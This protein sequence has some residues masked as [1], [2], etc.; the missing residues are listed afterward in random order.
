MGPQR[1]PA[2][3]AGGKE[4][5]AS[6]DRAR[7]GRQ[8]WFVP[9]RQHYLFVCTNLRPEGNPKGSC[10]AKGSEALYQALKAELFARGL[11]K[12]AARAC[13]SSCLDQCS[14][15]ASILVEPEHFFY[16]RVTTADVPEIVEAL[17]KGERVERL[18]MTGEDLERG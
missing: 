15:G 9:Q 17:A 6:L 8:S 4:Q 3:A 10:A 1:S 13:T 7:S 12:T 5:P 16:G 2:R 18:V 14:A 11:A